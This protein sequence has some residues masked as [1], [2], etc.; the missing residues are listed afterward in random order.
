MLLAS[1]PHA[2]I[3]WLDDLDSTAA[4]AERLMKAWLA[5]DEEP[6]AETL[7]VAER[8]RAG[9]GRG[10]HVWDSPQGGLYANWLAWVPAAAVSV[11]PMG[12][13]V[14]LASAVEALWPAAIVG[15]KWPN[16]LLVTGRKLGGIL[17][18]SRG[19]GDPMWVS[20]GFGINLT[21][22]PALAAGDDTQAVSLHNLGWTGD[23]REGTRALSQAFLDG[24]HGALENP[25]ATRTQWARRTVHRSGQKVQLYLHDEVVEGRFVGFDHSGF[26]ELEVE[27]CVRK[28][29]VGEVLFSG[30]SG[31]S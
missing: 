16:D 21:S 11:I 5:A 4:F 15:L 20:V 3:V 10:Q 18:Q 7:L 14:T 9:R 1:V 22:A 30:D 23:A 6:L 31:G 12:V 26:L 17:C 19:A 29:S 8:Q 2:N 24:I 13:G 28:Y 25:E 27:G